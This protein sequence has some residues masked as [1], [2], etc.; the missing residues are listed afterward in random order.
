M[1][2]ICATPVNSNY[3][4]YE[5]D[6]MN[7]LTPVDGRTWPPSIESMGDS[8]SISS[9]SMSSSYSPRMGGDES[10]DGMCNPSFPALKIV[11]QPQDKFRF[12]YKS[13]MMGTHGCI[14][15]QKTDRLMKT[16]PTVKLLNYH[17]GPVIIRCSLVGMVSNR[18]DPVPH[19]HRL[20]VR[21]LDHDK[22]EPQEITVDKN[23]DYTAVF[24]GMGIVHTARKHVV[25]ELIKKKRRALLE[26]IKGK[27][28]NDTCPTVREDLQ[29]REDAQAESKVMNLNIVHLCFEAL[30]EDSRGHLRHICEKVVS[31][32]IR[33]MKCAQ[34]GE[35]KICRIDKHVSCCL[36]GE[37]V[38]ILVEKVAKKNIQIRFFELDDEDNEIW[39]DFGKFTELD[40][41]HQ[42]AVVFRTPRYRDVNIEHPVD[43]FLQ[44]YRPSDKDTSEPIRFTYKPQPQVGRKRLRTQIS[45][46][47]PTAVV[48]GFAHQNESGVSHYSTNVVGVQP[49]Q[50]EKFQLPNSVLE[51]L[52]DPGNIPHTSFQQDIFTD[53]EKLIG[54]GGSM[55]N[56]ISWEGLDSL[57]NGLAMDDVRAYLSRRSTGYNDLAV[58]N[59]K[60]H[61]ITMPPNSNDNDLAMDCA[62]L[63]ARPA[64]PN[65][66]ERISE[67]I[68]KKS[69][70]EKNNSLRVSSYKPT[71][72]PFSIA[73][74]KKIV[75]LSLNKEILKKIL[76]KSTTEGN[77][78]LHLLVTH[79]HTTLLKR[80]LI[81]LKK[82]SLMQY[83]DSTNDLLETPLHL[84][85]MH[86]DVEKIKL[87]LQAGANPG[88]RNIAGNNA[89]HLAVLANQNPSEEYINNESLVELLNLKNYIN[90]K[91]LVSHLDVANEAG[92]TPLHLA[93]DFEDVEAVRSLLAANCDVNCLDAHGGCS[94]LHMA[95]VADNI[96]VTQLLLS[97]PQIDVDYCNRRGVNALKLVSVIKG[98]NCEELSKLLREKLNIVGDAEDKKAESESGEE[99]DEENEGI[100]IQQCE[101][102]PVIQPKS[103]EPEEVS[104]DMNRNNESA[105][106]M[107]SEEVISALSSI[108]DASG[109]W[110]DL[111]SILDFDFLVSAMQEQ[112]SPSRA[113]LSYAD[114]NGGITVKTLKDVMELIGEE[115]AAVKLQKLLLV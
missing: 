100:P 26:L 11:E 73:M 97:H 21:I 15:G 45:E 114:V 113:L 48:Q 6:M 46:T 88:L 105:N 94:A 51:N 80:L 16:Y 31:T 82:H 44:L 59:W 63:P 98:K 66:Q 4:E 91:F 14:L 103:K 101:Q 54:E 110:K 10:G 33:N 28:E 89:F 111:A 32:S 27:R 35:L 39:E 25:E 77:M 2:L 115:A 72:Y 107:L 75:D 102:E 29:I 74:L 92:L 108:L 106:S 62:A 69:T 85:I 60:L 58:D 61:S 95:V 71:R 5:R 96:R 84:S 55:E 78:I 83:I 7:Y 112:S 70:S 22:E 37:D 68:K 17:G 79:Q 50:S 57:E 9:P 99:D 56:N 12:R 53:I 1:T 81:L 38:F 86:N 30:C 87:L 104:E 20:I 52:P 36:G 8:S 18:S 3:L 93:V 76:E 41:H 13:E 64:S 34:T 67:P 47:I 19:A 24:Q 90:S 42:Y 43:V 109:K 49:F 23:N 40:V 65:Q